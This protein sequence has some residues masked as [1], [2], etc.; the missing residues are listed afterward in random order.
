MTLVGLDSSGSRAALVC[1]A[2]L[3]KVFS[4]DSD[5]FLGAF[6]SESAF[7]SCCFGKDGI[8]LAGDAAGIVHFLSVEDFGTTF[9]R[10]AAHSA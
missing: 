4:V 8:I 2:A 5:S 6:C 10:L 3:L 7:L 1:D 9:E